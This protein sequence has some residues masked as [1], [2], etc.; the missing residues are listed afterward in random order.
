MT[1]FSQNNHQLVFVGKDVAK[2]TTTIAALNDGEIALFTPGGTM[3]TEATADAGDVFGI[4]LG[5]AAALGPLRSPF[6]SKADVKKVTRKAYSAPTAQ[7]DYIG[8]NTSTGSIAVLNNTVYRATM[9]IDGSPETE[10]GGIYIKDM[11]YESDSAATQAEIADG[12]F[13]NAVANF[14]RD[15]EPVIGFEMTMAA[16]S[17]LALG[18]GVNNVTFTNGSKTVLADDIDDATTNAAFA[19]GDYIRIGTAATD[20]VYRITA[21]DAT[22]NTATLSVPFQGT[23]QTIADTGL[24]RIAAASAATVACGLKLTA[25]T[26]AFTV[27][28]LRDKQARWELSLDADSFTTTTLTNSASAAPGN[29]TYR[30]VAELEW[31]ANGNNGEMFRMGEPNIYDVTLHANSAETYDCIEI[32]L[33]RGRTDSLGYVNSP[34]VISLFI[35]SGKDTSGHYSLAATADDITDMLEDLLDGVPVY[36][37]AVTANGGALTTGDLALT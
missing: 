18:T 9:Q 21:I 8:Y 26:L 11:V 23:T 17:D 32:E 34:Q 35:D 14:S 36:G 19:V 24:K 7:V 28:K 20:E 2:T 33:E 3:Y 4:Y 10:H 5:R 16:G 29:G 6:F 31:F 15:A 37:G 1:N 30:Q 12:L 22:A 25:N 27:G 13:A